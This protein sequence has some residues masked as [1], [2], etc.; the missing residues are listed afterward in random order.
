MGLITE[1]SIYIIYDI[2]YLILWLA[3]YI[4]M[5]VGIVEIKWNNFRNVS[6]KVQD[7]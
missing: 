1:N 7:F 5:T 6:D 3:T 4:G 2:K